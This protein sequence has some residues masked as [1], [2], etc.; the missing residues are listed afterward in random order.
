LPRRSHLALAV[1]A[2]VLILAATRASP[3]PAGD[4]VDA[5][6]E[7]YGFAGMHVLTD[8]TSAEA[9][10]TG[11]TLTTELTTQGLASV[12]VDLRSSSVVTGALPGEVPRPQ[13]YTSQVWRN[14]SDRHYEVKYLN[15][16]QV[17]NTSTPM[18]SVAARLDVTQLR[19]TVDQLTAYY[20]VERQLARRGTCN[21]TVPV[22]D[23]SELYRL[24]FTDL[25]DEV[26]APTSRQG[27]SG[28]AH[29]C[30]VEREMIVANPDKKEST[31]DR[32]RLWYARLLPTS[33]MTPVR[34]EYDTAFGSVEGYLA[35]LVGL[36]THLKLASE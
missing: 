10:T 6:F 11:Y 18:T 4:R 9:S 28:P 33:Q 24:H 35:E 7:I 20:L 19:G 16:G 25:R 15:D 30:Q 2:S 31:Y 36:G 21:L 17:I 26:L 5:R 1:G 29:L 23:G 13:S 12:F 8:R 32:G 27:Y 22:F 3:A 14:G 34:M